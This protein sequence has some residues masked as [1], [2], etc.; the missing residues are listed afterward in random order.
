MK[1]NIVSSKE[2]SFKI[3]GYAK[4]ATGNLSSIEGK[5]FPLPG[6][7]KIAFQ[8]KSEKT[9]AITTWVQK[10][11]HEKFSIFNPLFS[12]LSKNPGLSGWQLKLTK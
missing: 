3:Q 9:G 12:S 2:F 4:E 6:S 1:N 8:M 10:S 5:T 11:E 7:G